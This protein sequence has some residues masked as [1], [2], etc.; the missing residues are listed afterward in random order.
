MIDSQTIEARHHV[1]EL[2][3]I[4]TKKNKIEPWVVARMERATTDL[5]DVT[6]Y[7]EGKKMAKGGMTEHG[8]KRGD[9]IVYNS[10]NEVMVVDKNKNQKLVDIDKGE[11]LMKGG[12][13]TGWKHKMKT[14]GPVKERK[15]PINYKLII[16]LIKGADRKTFMFNCDKC[17]H[18]LIINLKQITSQG[19]WCSYCSHQKLCENKECNMCFNNSFAS[20]ERSKHLNDKNINTRMLF[21]STNKKFNFNCDTC[22][23]IFSCQLSD[24]TK[25]IWCSFCVNKTELILFNKLTEIYPTLK[26]QYKVNLF[27]NFNF[28]LNRSCGLY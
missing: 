11:R 10:G 24:I 15:K 25:G 23:Q 16:K 19:H 13:M 7:L 17:P 27:K 12:L 4:L 2:S 22:K 5:S 9:T 18:K 14:G 28:V 8:L 26:R 1:E 21:K 3:K 6:H 20:V